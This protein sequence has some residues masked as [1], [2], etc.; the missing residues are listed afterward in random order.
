MLV[1]GTLRCTIEG[2]TR[3]KNVRLF[4]LRRFRR[5]EDQSARGA[6]MAALREVEGLASGTG[7]H[8]LDPKMR[9]KQG[10][11]A[12]SAEDYFPFFSFI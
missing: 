12:H 11:E 4:M 5:E 10:I 3:A 1:P 8:E 7:L 9:R 6:H 2:T